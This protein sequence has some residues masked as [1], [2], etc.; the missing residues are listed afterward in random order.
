MSDACPW[1]LQVGGCLPCIDRG[2]AV[3]KRPLLKNAYAGAELHREQWVGQSPCS[4]PCSSWPR[5]LKQRP[6]TP[7]GW[8]SRPCAGRRRRPR[9]RLRASATTTPSRWSMRANGAVVRSRP[10]GRDRRRAPGPH[11]ARD[12]HVALGHADVA[13][14]ALGPRDPPVAA[15]RPH[16]LDLAARAARTV[17]SRIWVDAH[18]SSRRVNLMLGTHVM[19]SFV[20]AV[21]AAGSP[22]PTGRFSVTDPIA[23]GDPGGPFGW[24][25]FGLSGHQPNL[26]AGWSGGDQ[27]AIHGTNSPVVA[28]NGR[29][30]RAACASR[31]PRSASSSATCTRARRSSSRRSRPPRGGLRLPHG[32]WRSLVA[33]LLWEQGVASSNLAVPIVRN[34]RLAGGTLRAHG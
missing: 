12:D 10:N 21:G 5:H 18:V 26:P 4:W 27:L 3:L 8:A 24:Y 20:A 1:L 31:R 15:E 7:S 33:H 23:T 14:R 30:R 11:A 22:T 25:A 34:V 13:R 9:H 19:R 32:T 29:L 6:R 2:A 28:R 16:R 17:K